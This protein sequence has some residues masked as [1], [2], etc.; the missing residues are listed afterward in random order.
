MYAANKFWPPRAMMERIVSMTRGEVT[1]NDFL[2]VAGPVV[3]RVRDDSPLAALE[4]AWRNASKEDR[5]AFL[6]GLVR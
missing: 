3:T 4:R 2:G 6:A 1:P 5:R